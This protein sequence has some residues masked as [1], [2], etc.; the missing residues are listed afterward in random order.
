MR[1]FKQ[2]LRL[3]LQALLLSMAMQASGASLSIGDQAP[4]FE[5]TTLAGE[6]FKL[7]DY[8]GDKPIY[9]KF[10]A[11]WCS[12]CKV[13]MP[14]LQAIH[15]EYGD[16]IEVL[17]VNVGINDSVANIE[18]F[19]NNKGFN[20]PVMIDQ[21]GDLVSDY[22]IVGTPHHVLIDKEGKIAYRT[23]LASD[24]LDSTIEG[25]VEESSNNSFQ[26]SSAEMAASTNKGKDKLKLNKLKNKSADLDMNINMSMKGSRSILETFDG[27]PITVKENTLTHLVFQEIW[28]SYEGHG[29]ERLLATLPQ[30]FRDNTQTIW[31]QPGINVTHAQLAEYQGYF[32]K[33]SPLVLDQGHQLMR[34][35][36][37]W[38]LPLHVLLKDGEK[39]FAGKSEQLSAL[40]ESH[41]I[42]ETRFN[43]WLSKAGTVAGQEVNFQS[44]E[45]HSEKNSAN[46][47]LK[48]EEPISFSVT[49]TLKPKYHKLNTGEQAPEF[50]AQT[51]AGKAASLTAIIEDKPVSLVFVDSLCP[52]PHFPGCEAKLA[53]L[54]DLVASDTSREWLGIVSSYYVTEEIAQQFREK[55][56]LKLP[57]IFDADNKIYQSYG[58]HASPYQIDISREGTVL[59]R[60]GNLR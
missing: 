13:E 1:L 15:D 54:N 8:K 18:Q 2:S 58:V 37:G 47:K 10:W 46:N 39:V 55:F 7:S 51:M 9:L 19:F 22:G 31:V 16:A 26:E 60:G 32:P 35:M 48:H 23:F 17:A 11:T 12:Y 30:V 41:F 4:D 56:Q 49:E 36:G 21:Q 38:D 24:T 42:N 52:M 57:L 59:S 27:Q 3:G 34:S 5:V 25:W 29:E 40:V 44:R 43:E 20:L 45:K 50:T 28:T 14:H 53:R 6:T 33:I